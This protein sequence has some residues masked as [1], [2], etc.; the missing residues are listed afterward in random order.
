VGTWRT[1]QSALYALFCVTPKSSQPWQPLG[2][3][4]HESPKHQQWSYSVDPSTKCL[5][6][7]AELAGIFQ[8][9]HH[10]NSPRLFHSTPII[11]FARPSKL[12]PVTVARSLQQFLE[13]TSHPMLAQEFEQNTS[14]YKSTGDHIDS[15]TYTKS[16]TSASQYT[17]TLLFPLDTLALVA[18]F[19]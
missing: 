8:C 16:P 12:I 18:E 17:W 19:N 9:F 5:V 6:H 4:Q 2:P 3:C 14:P 7:C 11:L 15:A 13:L 1:W 10:A